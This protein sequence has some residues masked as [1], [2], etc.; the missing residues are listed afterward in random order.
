MLNLF[1]GSKES[2]QD[3]DQ[4]EDPTEDENVGQRDDAFGGGEQHS[5][6]S[7]SGRTRRLAASTR[8]SVWNVFGGTGTLPEAE[9]DDDPIS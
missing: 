4:N 9:D 6:P 2:H 1:G 5:A 3:G 8:R 7:S